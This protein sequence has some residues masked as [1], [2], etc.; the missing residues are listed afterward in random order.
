MR[1]KRH[2]GRVAVAAALA[3]SEPEYVEAALD[4]LA[5]SKTATLAREAIEG[6]TSRGLERM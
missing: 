3:Q 5:D 6:V 4:G 2:R 1:P